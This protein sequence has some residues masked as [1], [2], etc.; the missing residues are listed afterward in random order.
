[1][2]DLK[3]Y[4]LRFDAGGLIIFAII[5]IPNL[6]WFA[7]PAGNDI[8]RNDSI[9]PEIDFVASIFQVIMVAA[10]CLIKNE[11]YH[12]CKNQKWMINMVA[13]IVIYFLG[14]CLYYGQITNAPVILILC[15]A[16]CATFLI[17]SFGKKNGVA[18][19]SAAIFMICHLI[20]GYAN[21]I[22]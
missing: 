7:V 22:C 6:I 8:L 13:T 5:M 4:I 18:F 14:W 2:F 1:M 19:V 15:V 16:P 9:T 10:L 17:Y 21:F 11:A 20:Y 12:K 3:K